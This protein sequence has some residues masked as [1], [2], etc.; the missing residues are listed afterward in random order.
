MA[1]RTKRPRRLPPPNANSNAVYL[2]ALDMLGRLTR[3][4]D[5]YEGELRGLEQAHRLTLDRLARAEQQLEASRLAAQIADDERAKFERERDH[6]AG[7]FNRVT[8][9]KQRANGFQESK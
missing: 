7:E 9:T 4:R 2:L 3:D 5:R 8:E 6:W 1:T